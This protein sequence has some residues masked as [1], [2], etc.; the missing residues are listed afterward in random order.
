MSRDDRDKRGG[1]DHRE[2]TWGRRSCPCCDGITP[3]IKD[4]DNRTRRER[5]AMKQEDQS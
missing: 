5:E 1:H 3:A 4:P 2:K